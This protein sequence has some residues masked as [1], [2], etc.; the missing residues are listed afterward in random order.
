MH[1]FLSVSNT[2]LK[3]KKTNN[4]TPRKH[5]QRQKNEWRDR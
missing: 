2:M 4:P 3:L 1:N 5:P